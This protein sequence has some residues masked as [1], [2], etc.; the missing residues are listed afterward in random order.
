MYCSIPMEKRLLTIRLPSLS[1]LP[2]GRQRRQTHVHGGELG[3]ALESLNLPPEPDSH[4]I[5]GP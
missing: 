4:S 1:A 3:P 5:N 2:G